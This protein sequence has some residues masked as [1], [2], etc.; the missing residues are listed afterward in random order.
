MDLT[1][2]IFNPVYVLFL[3]LSFILNLVIFRRLKMIQLFNAE[4]KVSYGRRSD[5]KVKNN[6]FRRWILEFV[7]YPTGIKMCIYFASI[8]LS[9]VLILIASK[10]T[11]N[12]YADSKELVTNEKIKSYNLAS[13]MSNQEIYLHKVVAEEFHSGNSIDKYTYV[14]YHLLYDGDI[15]EIENDTNIGIDIVIDPSIKKPHV[16][17]T[18]NISFYAIPHNWLTTFLMPNKYKGKIDYIDETY[19][20]VYLRSYDEILTTNL[21]PKIPPK[22]K[23]STSDILENPLGVVYIPIK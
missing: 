5:D 20:V 10:L 16:D 18:R 14:T 21:V 6:I 3:I 4:M 12:Y 2:L 11:T 19:Y 13:M 9:I 8:I 23:T 17:I 1:W 7:R 15:H 22:D